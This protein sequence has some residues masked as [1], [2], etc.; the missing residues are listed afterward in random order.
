M[1]RHISSGGTPALRSR[2]RRIGEGR[3]LTHTSQAYRNLILR[4][5]LNLR[6]LPDLA[7]HLADPA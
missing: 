7:D 2:G 1:T 5:H 6:F 4:C 3:E